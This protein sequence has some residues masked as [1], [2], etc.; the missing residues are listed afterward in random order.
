MDDLSSTKIETPH[1]SSL[2]Q[3]LDSHLHNLRLFRILSDDLKEKD[4]ISCELKPASALADPAAYIAVSYCWTEA[5]PSC[6]ILVNDVRMMIR[7]N[8]YA[9]LKIMRTERQEAWMFVDAICINQDDIEE[10][11]HQVGLMGTVFADADKVIVWLGMPLFTDSEIE[12][13]VNEVCETIK[14]GIDVVG[15]L[16]PRERDALQSCVETFYPTRYWSRVWVIQEQLLARNLE[17]RAGVL[18]MEEEAVFGLVYDS[19]RPVNIRISVSERE[20]SYIKRLYKTRRRIATARR[21]G[22]W[23]MMTLAQA[24]AFTSGQQCTERHDK[25]CGLLG[26]TRKQIKI[27]YRMPTE[28]L[29]LR[30]VIAGLLEEGKLSEHSR[31]GDSLFHNDEEAQQSFRQ[32]FMALADLPRAFSLPLEDSRISVLLHLAVE[33][34]SAN[35]VWKY[36]INQLHRGSVLNDR[37]TGE[38]VGLSDVKGESE[39]ATPGLLTYHGLKASA[40]TADLNSPMKAQFH[41]L[42]SY[43]NG[44]YQ[45]MAEQLS[46]PRYFPDE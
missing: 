13:E 43:V 35:E 7:P 46:D 22:E 4:T 8:L 20:F 6:S 25:V 2:Y 12:K 16:S 41:D 30:T 26:L 36:N 40:E 28:E 21:S 33:V 18:S 9:F 11:N 44:L 34:C 3:P 17:F 1:I 10:R 39:L 42:V 31:H 23:P 5:A 27:D 14:Q 19:E 32:A 38:D 24:I 15:R 29:V 37:S 45:E